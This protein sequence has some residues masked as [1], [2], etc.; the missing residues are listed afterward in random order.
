MNWNEIVDKI[1]PY[2]VKIETPE[3]HGTGFL[4][5]YNEER[6]LAGIAT[7]SHVVKNADDWQQPIR[8]RHYS[9][10]KTAFFKESERVI[11]T[12]ED[13][14]SAVILCPLTDLE[15][16]QTLIPLFPTD[17]MLEIGMEVGWLGFPA[18]EA[19][20]LCFFSGNISARR[21][22]R[23]SYFIDGV[24]INGVSGGPVMFASPTAGIQIVGIVSAY[25]ANRTGAGVYPGLL[26]AQDVS[27]FHGV[28]QY[29]QS[30]DEAKRKKDEI[31]KASPDTEDSTPPGEPVP[32][33]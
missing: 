6:N 8:V 9:S 26:V 21:E 22:T 2:I 32:P 3:G 5:L 33:A 29:I 16:P 28:T 14:D 31:A 30:I 4:Y 11:F 15:L 1:T 18:L 25:F 24:A 7:A 13:T 27:H 12:D 20:T 19:S 17:R 23:K 10:K